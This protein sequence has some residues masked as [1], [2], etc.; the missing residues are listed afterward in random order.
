MRHCFFA[1]WSSPVARQAHNL[2][3]VGSNPTPATSFTCCGVSATSAVEPRRPMALGKLVWRSGR[4]GAARLR[5]EKR[6]TGWRP[7]ASGHQWPTCHPRRQDNRKIPLTSERKRSTASA[8]SASPAFRSPMCRIG[9]R[10]KVAIAGWGN[11]WGFGPLHWKYPKVGPLSVR[12]HGVAR[13]KP[14]KLGRAPRRTCSSWAV[15]IRHTFPG[16]A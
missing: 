9:T 12:S 16:R 10:W 14:L 3:V 7:G 8:R 2:K 1:G 15:S 6:S 13:T 5:S 11:R 4:Y